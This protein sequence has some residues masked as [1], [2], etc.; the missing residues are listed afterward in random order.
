MGG[1]CVAG[2]FA[3][4]AGLALCAATVHAGAG[5]GGF[6]NVK[7]MPGGDPDAGGGELVPAAELGEGDAEAVG[8]GNQGVSAAGGVVNGVCGWG[9]GRS[10]GHNE[11]FDAL[12]L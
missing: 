1:L 8:D 10:H 3:G 6:G 5:E 7:A 12:K 11:G 2:N 9:S 4:A